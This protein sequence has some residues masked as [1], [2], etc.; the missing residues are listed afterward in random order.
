MSDADARQEISRPLGHV[1]VVDR[2]GRL[3]EAGTRSSRTD[4]T[5]GIPHAL[6]FDGPEGVGKFRTALWWASRIKCELQ[7][8]GASA[9]QDRICRCASC[10]Q[11]AVGTHP[12]VLVLAPQAGE[13]ILKIE[14]IR[15]T[16][17]PTLSLRPVR[18]GP[19][20]AIVR[21]AELLNVAAQ[22]A[23]LKVLEEPPGNAVIILVTGSRSALLPTIR[24]R[25]QTVRFGPLDRESLEAILTARGFT[26][27]NARS[28]AAIAR[29]SAGKALECDEE[30]LADRVDLILAF[31]GF[32]SGT[33]PTM[34]ELVADLVDRRKTERAELPVLLEWQ[35]R[36]IE[37][38]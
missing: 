19:R 22:N 16:L 6:L 4:R 37:T 27:D 30:T 29:G 5:H 24:S 2:L 20:V 36:K 18:P 15:S 7:G 1:A 23:M 13:K 3:A 10:Q 35:L 14:L 33:G 9:S 38:A 26:P 31:E 17:I 21:G 8:D 28:A 12:D 11:V 32:R 25:C 34:E